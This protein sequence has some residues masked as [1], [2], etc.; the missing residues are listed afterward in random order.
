MRAPFL[1]VALLALGCSK[2]AIDGEVVDA[3]G[4]PMEGATI[5]ALGAPCTTQTDATG[6]FSLECLPGSYQLV[7]GYEGYVPFEDEIE[8]TERKRYD[9]GKKILIKIPED[10]GLFLFAGDAYE[11]L[12]D[13]RLARKLEKTGQETTRA[14]CLDPEQSEP[15]DLTPGVYNFFDHAHIGWRP[16][17]LDADGCAYRDRKNQKHQWQVEYREKAQFEEHGLKDQDKTIARISF[18]EGD[19]FIA[20]WK[21]FFTPPA[22]EKHT[23]TGHWVR[24]RK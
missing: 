7:V 12:N 11:P 5:S 21:G 13:G 19:Y 6:K 9:I 18:E 4:A 15:N 16:F 8:A 24:V 2:M 14:F 10:K 17:K 23:Y 20:D 3:T 1:G 22:G